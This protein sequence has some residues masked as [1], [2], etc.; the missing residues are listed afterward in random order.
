MDE[1]GDTAFVNLDDISAIFLDK[2]NCDQSIIYLKSDSENSLTAKGKP[3]EVI[4][5]D[6]IK[7]G[8]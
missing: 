7:L 4:S 8:W 2:D 5:G 1:D 3:D 6:I